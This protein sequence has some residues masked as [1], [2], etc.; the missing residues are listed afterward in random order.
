MTAVGLIGGAA[1]FTVAA[2]AVIRLLERIAVALEA[3]ARIAA[4]D[5][6]QRIADREARER[7][8]EGLR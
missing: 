1:L 5:E 3:G 7:L 6:S 2:A 4:R 8:A